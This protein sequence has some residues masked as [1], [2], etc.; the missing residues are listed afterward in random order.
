MKRIIV[1][2]LTG[3]LASC[4]GFNPDKEQNQ[5][6]QAF[7]RQLSAPLTLD[8][9]YIHRLDTLEALETSVLKLFLAAPANKEIPGDL[10][11]SIKGC[12][13]ID[14]LQQA[15]RYPG[16][17]DSL[18]AGMLK[19]AMAFKIGKIVF[20]KRYL[21]LW[22]I[23]EISAESYPQ[24]SATSIIATWPDDKNK[25]THVLACELYY[26]ADPPQIMERYTNSSVGGEEILWFSETKIVQNEDA[27]AQKTPGKMV[28]KPEAGELKFTKSE[29]R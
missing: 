10:Q 29:G 28:I 25:F 15:G 5:A 24:Y 9:V 22:G 3:V 26:A 12:L 2:V 4:A 14:S 17:L 23:N 16:Y 13:F 27:A 18:Q 21:L 11:S 8:S 1:C 19:N 6:A 7:S 20:G